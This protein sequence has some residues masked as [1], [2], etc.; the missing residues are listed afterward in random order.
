MIRQRGYQLRSIVLITVLLLLFTMVPASFASMGTTESCDIDPG[1]TACKTLYDGVNG[2]NADP[3]LTGIAVTTPPNKTKYRP[4]DYFD[5]SGMVVMAYY[6]DDTS[7]IITGYTYSPDTPLGTNDRKILVSYGG[8]ITWQNISVA[9]SGGGGSVNPH[10]IARI[11]SAENVKPGDMVDLTVSIDDPVGIAGYGFALQYDPSILTPIATAKAGT[12]GGAAV[13]VYNPDYGGSGDMIFIAWAGANAITSEGSLAIVSFKVNA[14]AKKGTTTV[15]WVTA[16][17][18]DINANAAS[19]I[20]FDGQI[21]I[22]K[23]STG[24]VSSGGGGGGGAVTPTVSGLEI[25]SLPGKINY[26][27][28]E[29]LDLTGLV[30]TLVYSNGNKEEIAWQDFAAKGIVVSPEN[31][32]ILDVSLR[33]ILIKAGGKTEELAISVKEVIREDLPVITIPVVR[34]IDIES[35]WANAAIQQLMTAGIISGYPDNT[36]RPDT[37]ITRAEFAIMLVKALDLQTNTSKT[38]L[39]TADHWANEYIATAVAGGIVQGYNNE[40]FGPDDMITREQ[41]AVMIG[42][43]AQLNAMAGELSYS[44]KN[45]AS[46]WAR[47]WIAAVIESKLMSGYPDNT[48][49]PQA[50]A[51]RAEAANVTAAFLNNKA[52]E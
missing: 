40:E 13:P 26:N 27:E 7:E 31:G 35:H 38:F 20:T 30:V 4:G 48:F 39:D 11:G 3:V 32:F 19:L 49:K 41:I 10:L 34:P 9:A 45:D 37:K 12:A 51:T 18:F 42:K 8:F 21:N 17:K 22:V 43:A 5:P 6:D 44:D 29:L 14:E 2:M 46:D 23:G 1:S 36:F 24:A 28:G 52:N 25:K 47:G 15:S 16:E 50:N 33:K